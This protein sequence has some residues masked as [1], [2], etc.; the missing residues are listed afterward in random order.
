MIVRVG[1]NSLAVEATQ[2]IPGHLLNQFSMD[3]YN[4]HLR[5]AVTIGDRNSESKNDVYVLD[6]D[7]VIVGSVIDLGLTERIYSARFIGDR[8]YLVTFR[9]IDP[10]YVLDLS[11]PA[12]PKMVGEL[13][14][15]GYSAYLE[16]ISDRLIL[17]VGREEGKVK[18]SLFDVSDSKNPIEKS[19]YSLDESWT[20]I[21]SNHHAFLRDPKH[22][23]IFIPSGKGGYVIS[24]AK[25]TL[26]LSVAVASHQMKR[27]LFIEDNLYI[28]AED[29]ITVLDEKTWKETKSLILN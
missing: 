18:M 4:G 8:G 26:S 16:P 21:E 14:I 27:A 1:L 12:S 19:K 29:K 6:R 7:L 11:V 17:G 2:T 9:Q 20:D 24:Y 22:E 25:E 23:V 5:V 28:I 13:K 3:E 10:F 15:P